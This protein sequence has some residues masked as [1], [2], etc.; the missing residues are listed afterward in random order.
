MWARAAIGGGALGLYGWRIA[1]PKAS[2]GAFFDA[3]DWLTGWIL[4]GDGAMAWLRNVANLVLI[5]QADG[6][7]LGLAAFALLSAI[8]WPFRACGRWC[9]GRIR[10]FRARRRGP[11][12]GAPQR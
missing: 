4:T 6:F 5:D 12:N 1:D 8:L 10:H 9:A 3:S 11:D 7:L 2:Y